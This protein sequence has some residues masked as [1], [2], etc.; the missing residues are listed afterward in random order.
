MTVFIFNFVF[1]KKDYQASCHVIYPPPDKQYHVAISDAWLGEMYGDHHI[2]V[3][4]G[5]ELHWGIPPHDRGS[6]FMRALVTGLTSHSEY[7]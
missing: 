4:R 5:E 1:D 7:Q 2:I 3:A 6:E